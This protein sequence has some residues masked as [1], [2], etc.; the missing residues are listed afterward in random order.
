M[1][2]HPKLE[3]A[4]RQQVREYQASGLSRQ[5][6]CQQKQIPVPQLDYWKRKFRRST[7]KSL[8]SPPTPWIP[9]TIC[10]EPTSGADTGIRLWLGRARVEVSR[11]FDRQVLAEV[12]QVAGSVC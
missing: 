3:E 1:K 8:V 5:E 12:L 10:E 9:V 7:P 2:A 4:W 6:Y 11:G